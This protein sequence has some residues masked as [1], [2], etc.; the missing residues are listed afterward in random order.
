[1]NYELTLHARKV[2]EERA[3]AIEWMERA[4]ATPEEV[5][6]DPN[7]PAIQRFYCQIPEF[8]G[9]TLRVAVNTLVNPWRVV[10]VF[11]DRNKRTKP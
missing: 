3:I 7:D 2:L 9:R 4:L 11:F 1:M 6:P 10:S 8:G 5:A